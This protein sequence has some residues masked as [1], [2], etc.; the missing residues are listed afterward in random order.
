M[1]GMGYIQGF[2]IKNYRL[3]KDVSL[4]AIWTHAMSGKEG[5]PLQEQGKPLTPITVVIGRNGY[6]KSTLCDA[7]GFIVDCLKSDAEQACISRGG[8]DK[9]ASENSDRIIEFQIRYELLL[10]TLCIAA[11]EYNVPFVFAETLSHVDHRLG[12]TTS[13]NFFVKSGEGKVLHPRLNTI[14]DV[15]LADPRRSVLSTLGNLADYPDIV[16]FREFLDSWYLCCFTPD[17]A[18]VPPLAGPQKH[19]S[20]SGSNL[21]NVVQYWEREH[22]GR[23]DDML[24]RVLGKV[25]G[26]RKIETHQTEDGRLLLRF[27]EELG[28]QKPFYA[29][30]MSDGTLKLVAYLLLLGD[31]QPP[32]LICFEEPENGLYHRLLGAFVDEIRRYADASGGTQFFITTHQ[33]YLVDALNPNEVWILD[34]GSDAFATVRR[35]SDD[36][37]VHNMVAEGMPLGA[38]WFSE[39]LDNEYQDN[40]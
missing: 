21:A 14:E 13:V 5:T 28:M 7:L 9:I 18:R 19:L 8:F 32:P 29:S 2:R 4:G 3:L 37:I 35:A 17:A 27:F 10:Y 39:Y 36:A 30:Q 15:R 22:Q 40:V 31:P 25:L 20:R 26:I 34:K 16:A 38:L 12:G 23:L 33:P 11:N 24:N 1:E 6:G